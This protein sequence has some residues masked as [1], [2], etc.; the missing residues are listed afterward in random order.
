MLIGLLLP[1]L[2]RFNA[3]IRMLTGAAVMAAGLALALGL[4]ARGHPSGGTLLLIRIGF[5]LTLA[6][7]VQFGSGVRGDRR[8]HQVSG[9]GPGQSHDQP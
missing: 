7:F 9:H 3:R 6:G 5:L 1:L 4:L 2:R 8:G